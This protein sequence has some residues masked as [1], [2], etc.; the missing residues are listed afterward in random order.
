MHSFKIPVPRC[1][2]VGI[3]NV[4]PSRE[5]RGFGNSHFTS[6]SFRVWE[7]PHWDIFFCAR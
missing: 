1:L 4:I 5:D 6:T 3:S 2:L 7:I